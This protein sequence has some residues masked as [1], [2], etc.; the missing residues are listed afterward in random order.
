ME[1]PMHLESY[2]IET[3]G[4][5]EIRVYRFD[6]KLFAPKLGGL[7][8]AFGFSTESGFRGFLSKK[9]ISCISIEGLRSQLGLSP[10]ASFIDEEGLSSIIKDRLSGAALETALNQLNAAKNGSIDLH[11]H[12]YEHDYDH[13]DAKQDEDGDH[14]HEEDQDDVYPG[15]F[16]HNEIGDDI[17]EIDKLVDL[18]PPPPLIRARAPLLPPPIPVRS[19]VPVAPVRSAAFVHPGSSKKQLCLTLPHG[20]DWALDE[21]YQ[22]GKIYSLPIYDHSKEL[23]AQLKQYRIFWES[24]DSE[25]RQGGKLAFETDSPLL[26]QV[27]P[28]PVSTPLNYKKFLLSPTKEFLYLP[29][30]RNCTAFSV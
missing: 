22:I 23:T 4:V 29:K 10:N 19:P 25:F 14:D 12:D 15:G 27:V 2:T 20:D 13:D 3:G 17:E 21:R 26:A 11:D 28:H 1:A 24:E 6:G 9:S 30:N 7:C 16:G 5:N 8:S 18:P